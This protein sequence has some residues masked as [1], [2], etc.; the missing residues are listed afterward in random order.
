[1]TI[2]M[3]CDFDPA[4]NACCG[5]H[6]LH[7]R[8]RRVARIPHG[9]RGRPPDGPC[10]DCG[11]PP[12]MTHI[13]G[14]GEEL[15]PAC[16]G[17]LWSCDC[18]DEPAPVSLLARQPD[19]EDLTVVDGGRPASPDGPEGRPPPHLVPFGAAAAPLRS[20]H[21]DD[22]RRV[23]TWALAQGRSGRRDQLAVALELVGQCRT[24]D[25]P[26]LRRPDVAELLGSRFAT[27][28][29]LAGALIPDDW[30][31]DLWTVVAWLRDT[32]RLAP[33]SDPWSALAEPFQCGAGLDGDGRRRTD[34]GDV[35]FP[36]Q[37]ALAHDPRCPPDLVQILVGIDWRGDG[38]PFVAYGTAPVRSV[39]PPLSVLDPLFA[40]ARLLRADEDPTAVALEDLAWCGRSVADRWAPALTFYRHRDDGSRL[41]APLA[42]D[43]SGSP[44]ATKPD[45]RRRSGFRWVPIDHPP[46]ALWRA[47]LGHLRWPAASAPI[48]PDGSTP[49]HAVADDAPW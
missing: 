19:L 44:W 39:V 1:M 49:L 10:P 42:L 40:Y 29:S 3:H 11:L 48:E 16:D 5:A 18:L 2:C 37:C 4:D 22:L 9:S 28:C 27:W 21:R 15:C 17:R 14:C 43:D 30:A 8:G 34:G 23:V 12:G 13:L 33:G 36:C 31:E 38:R 26:R 45:R 20:A 46:A 7:L 24:D 47:G 35:D 6:H 32:G 41:G 25:G